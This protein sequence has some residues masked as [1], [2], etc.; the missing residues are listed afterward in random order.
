MAKKTCPRAGGD[1]CL[2]A[3]AC[4]VEA[5]SDLSSVVRLGGRRMEDGWLST[6]FN[7]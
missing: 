3:G 5:L 6:L 1:S 2:S 7:P 4:R